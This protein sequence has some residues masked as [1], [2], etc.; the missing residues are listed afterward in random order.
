MKQM[1]EAF[2][3]LLQTLLRGSQVDAMLVKT[4]IA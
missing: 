1:Q 3:I 4:K 2:E